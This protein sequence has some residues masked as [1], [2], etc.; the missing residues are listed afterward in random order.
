MIKQQ[1]AQLLLLVAI[2]LTL[3]GCYVSKPISI[4][5]LKPAQVT[6]PP[7]V[8]K[9]MIAYKITDVENTDA[10]MHYVNQSGFEDTQNLDSIFTL[11]AVDYFQSLISNS[12]KYV[13]DSNLNNH[14]LDNNYYYTNKQTIASLCEKNQ[15]DAVIVLNRFTTHE[16]VFH[17]SEYAFLYPAVYVVKDISWHIYLKDGETFFEY[18]DKDTVAI[19]SYPYYNPDSY[20]LE[21]DREYLIDQV[22]YNSAEAFINYISPVWE[23]EKRTY[24]HS[25]KLNKGSR[26]AKKD[27]W[28]DAAKEWIKTTETENSYKNATSA[29]NMALAAEMEGNLELALYWINTALKYEN[30]E[31]IVAYKEIILRRRNEARKVEQQMP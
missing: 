2:L 9:V 13:L 31:E 5:V 3:S 26:F 24:Y 23:E 20:P 8:S 12:E 25:G 29:Y 14:K 16:Y 22:A 6:I 27:M 7:E 10:S 30:D 15:T 11:Q 21:V 28:K 17:S 4:Q 18:R 19:E 1:R